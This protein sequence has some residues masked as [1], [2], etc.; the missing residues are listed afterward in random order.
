MSLVDYN[1]DVTP[2]ERNPFV[3]KALRQFP[4]STDLWLRYCL[5]YLSYDA[6]NMI[7]CGGLRSQRDFYLR[8]D[9]KTSFNDMFNALNCICHLNDE[10]KIKIHA[11]SYITNRIGMLSRERTLCSTDIDEDDE[12]IGEGFEKAEEKDVV[13][14]ELYMLRV[15]HLKEISTDD[16][17]LS[18]LDILKRTAVTY[19]KADDELTK[20]SYPKKDVNKYPGA[21]RTK[22]GYLMPGEDK[23]LEKFEKKLDSN[24]REL[25][26]IK[27]PAKKAKIIKEKKIA[28]EQTSLKLSN[29]YAA[30][31]IAE[32]EI[33]KAPLA[34]ADRA[35]EGYSPPTA[36]RL[37]E[38]APLEKEF[39]NLSRESNKHKN[40]QTAFYNENRSNMTAKA[41]V[42]D[43]EGY[44]KKTTEYEAMKAETK[45]M[46]DRMKELRPL[47]DELNK[48]LEGKEMDPEKLKPKMPTAEQ[49]VARTAIK[50]D[51]DEKE[52]A[53]QK[54]DTV[55]LERE[56]AALRDEL[57]MYETMPHK[58]EGFIVKEPP[59][60]KKRSELEEYI[61]SIPYNVKMTSLEFG[62]P[63]AYRCMDSFPGVDVPSYFIAWKT[64]GKS[65]KWFSQSKIFFDKKVT[66]K[67]YCRILIAMFC[68]DSGKQMGKLQYNKRRYAE[69]VRMNADPLFSVQLNELKK[70]KG[71]IIFDAFVDDEDV[72]TDRTEEAVRNRDH[73]LSVHEMKASEYLIPLPP[74]DFMPVDTYSRL[75]AKIRLHN[76]FLNNVNV[77]HYR[78][79]QRVLSRE[80]VKL[81]AIRQIKF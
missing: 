54:R 81:S 37:A 56:L 5:V 72:F 60:I 53:L 17:K 8:G 66:K 45:R 18:Y 41:K 47:I 29:H 3:Q 57:A 23:V 43:P 14:Q 78:K 15:P 27:A 22:I 77:I 52:W 76:A 55:K 50:R 80:V 67:L 25:S 7:L 26:N 16:D 39:N 1:P 62:S 44:L 68:H 46:S 73:Y 64:M 51:N 28:I 4:L 21:I 9:F 32:E 12:F 13:V 19:S 10:T 24:I 42:S 34:V 36:R 71:E 75:V 33:Y 20:K 63:T 31:A 61:M 49:M 59:V 2:F 35:Y 65:K 79:G 70:E 74:E 6:F 30:L 69:I 40:K 58:A 38:V 48:L 11:P